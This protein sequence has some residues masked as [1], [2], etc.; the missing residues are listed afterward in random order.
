MGAFGVEFS[1]PK[2]IAE[3]WNMGSN[4]F[5]SKTVGRNDAFKSVGLDNLELILR[6]T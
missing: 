1:S 2:D 3:K 5:A 4:Y 6:K